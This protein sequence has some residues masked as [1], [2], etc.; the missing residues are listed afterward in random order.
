MTRQA[1][2]TRVIGVLL[3]GAVVAG[4]FTMLRTVND[5]EPGTAAPENAGTLDTD[6]LISDVG[7]RPDCPA[8]GAGGVELD[9]LGG[10]NAPVASSGITVVNVWPGGADR[11]ATSCRTYE[12]AAAHPEYTV[13][14][15]HATGTRQRRRHAR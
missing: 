1:V 4:A 8:T 2:W 7:E 6:A 13:V 9:C 14:G 12:F 5:P 11:A 3:T 10:E 15:V